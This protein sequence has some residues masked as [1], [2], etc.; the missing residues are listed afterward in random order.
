LSGSST[1]L[2]CPSLRSANSCDNCVKIRVSQ[3]GHSSC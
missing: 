1:T 2:H 3:H